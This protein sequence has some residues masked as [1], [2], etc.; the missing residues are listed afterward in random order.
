MSFQVANPFV[1]Q[2]PLVAS[3]NGATIA[4]AQLL[5][6][7][8]QYQTVTDFRPLVGE[9]KYHALQINLQKRFSDGLSGTFSYVWSKLMDTSGVGN[10]AAFLDPSAIQDINNYRRGEYSLSTL[11]VPHRVVGSFSYE[12]PFGNKKPFATNVGKLAN[13]FIGGWQLSGTATWQR[14]TP[15]LIVANGFTELTA[16]L[17]GSQNAVRRPNRVGPNTF[18]LD[19]FHTNARAGTAVID[20]NAFQSP[21][22]L[23]L[24]NGSRTYNDVRRD[25]YKNFDLSL[26][27][28][29][30]FFENKQKLQLRIEALNVFNLV[31]FGT[32]GNNINA[33]NFG[34]VT[35]QGNRPRILQLVGRYTF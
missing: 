18:N 15:I 29:F 25:S 26:I 30:G 2:I 10:G 20:I 24:G 4:R 16:A 12:L 5:R 23:V 34:I 17:T 32:P 28:N 3:L 11:D 7:F 19:T 6:R 33:A 27:K 9:S 14:G 31:V 35:T 13:T 8:P 21:S 1:G 22:S